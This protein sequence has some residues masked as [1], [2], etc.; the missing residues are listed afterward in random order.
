MR[1]RPACCHAGPEAMA[2]QRRRT[3]GFRGRAFRALLGLYPAAFRDEY[4]REMALVF[5][6]R[7]RDAASAFERSRL[8]L[9]VIAGILSEA[10]KEHVRMTVH[11]FRYALR[12]L[13]ASPGFALTSIATL[14]L[15]IGASTALFSVLNAVLLRPLPFEAPDRLTMLWTEIPSRGLTAGRSAY[16]SVEEWRKQSQS[17]SD[18]AVLDPVSSILTR[19]AEREQISVSRVSPNFFPLLGV[20][21]ALG[22]TFTLQEAD[23]RQ[24]LAVISHRLW[25]AR[26]GGSPAAIGASLELDGQASEI[27]GIMPAS[28]QSGFGADV[29][30][31]HTLFPDWE[32]RRTQQ[33]AGQWFVLAR[34]RPHATFGQAQAEM[35]A[36]AGRLDSQLPRAEQGRGI[37]LTAFSQYLTGA[38][39]RL[40]L[41]MLTAAAFG[42]LLVAIANVAGL[43]L[44]RSAGQV[45]EMA[46]RA[47]LGASRA[48]IARQLLAESVTVG[49]A[50]GVLGLLLA[51]AGIRVIRAYGPGNL[52]RLQEVGLD[53]NVLGWALA[54]TLSSGILVGFAPA[55]MMWRRDL[56]AAG[57]EGGRG[58]AGGAATRL[59][60]LLVVSECAVAIVLLVGAGLLVRSWW[61]V[62]RVDPGFQTERIL[63]VALMAPGSGE[64]GQRATFYQLVLEQV[65]SIAGVE[66]A[67][68][69]SELF[70]GSVGE[71]V[72]TVEGAD[73]VEGERLPF[74]TDEVSAG[75]FN[76]LGTPLV[77]GRL[78]SAEDGPRTERVAIV[79]EAMAS[80]IWPGRDP[81]GRRFTYGQAGSGAV[82]LTV[83]GVVGNMRRQGLETE[84]VPQI[85]E[86]LVQNPPRRAILFV[87][88]SLA[89]PL[90]LA[91]P[92]RAAVGRADSRAVVY[93]VGTVDARL[94]ELV[95]ERRLQTSLLTGFSVVALLLST[96]G[97]Y[98]LIQYSVATRS[99]EIGLRMALG[100]RAEDIFRMV[101][102]EGLL[103]SVTGLVLGLV[104]ALWLGQ[105]GSSLLFGVT[106]TDPMTFVAV[107]L[108]V[109]VVA[110]AA[111]YVPARRAMRVA[112]IVAL[113][114]R[115]M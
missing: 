74:R 87:R 2:V 76:T 58:I 93:G 18:I 75:F 89:E 40:V 13:R 44:A 81:I 67:S 98:G 90:Q 24:R 41:W 51:V 23:D 94:G 105:V 63:S 83:V 36:I 111:C 20:Q 25:Q 71:R 84:P 15:A 60:R 53:V 56:R 97:I 39:P 45:P 49:A 70:V 17:F 1:A 104:G 72:L 107:S 80:R 78:F 55:M 109:M 3:D 30:E 52:A 77:R 102:R 4:G 62:M 112:P 115:V 5:S 35:S 69:S 19:G 95:A 27:V 103:L 82:W 14:A 26:F 57:A 47:A 6:D 79:N 10:P 85:F 7:Y 101:L 22:R 8:W 50:A 110:C 106:A 108:L 59:R 86:A 99:H 113:Q 43:S 100:A 9:E 92:L 29:W 68:V 11:D 66:S 32:R 91:A 73:R 12:R 61:N 96:I 48:R 46:I 42:L 114:Q 38:R 37:S 54:V 31:P 28:M 88:T 21:P 16:G 33:G 65:T 64:V 34:L